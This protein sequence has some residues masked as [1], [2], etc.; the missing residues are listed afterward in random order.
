VKKWQHRNDSYTAAGGKQML[1][2]QSVN[3]EQYV[4]SEVVEYLEVRWLF[5]KELA[6]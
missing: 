6:V 1:S 3:D 2:D 5:N 4:C